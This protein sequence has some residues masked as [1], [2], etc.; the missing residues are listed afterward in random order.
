MPRQV[1]DRKLRRLQ[2]ELLF[3]TSMVETALFESVDV[4]KRRDVDASRRLIMGDRWI[5][6]KRFSIES[7]VLTLIATQQP[8]AS[9]MRVLAAMLEIA[10]DL[11]RIGDYAKGI[12]NI[13]LMMAPGELFLPLQ[14]D[15]ARMAAK[16]GDMLHRSLAI[17]V[18]RNAEAA[19]A[20]LA[21]DD[22]VDSLYNQVYRKIV[23]L[24]VAAPGTIDQATYLLWVAHNLERTADRV[25]N[26]CERTVFAVSGEAL[27]LNVQ[28]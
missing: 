13:N 11:E 9:D 27:V 18:A 15:I 22:E 6:K 10:M 26:I 28:P 12:A 1:F 20:L 24:M 19:R 8:M 2:D 7:S 3:L 4:L 17:F 25:C 23:A 21:E 14:V 5:N 16:A